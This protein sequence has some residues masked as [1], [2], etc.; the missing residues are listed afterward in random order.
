MN[1]SIALALII[2][3]GDF[4]I[5]LSR[6]YKFNSGLSKGKL[7]YTKP[8]SNDSANYELPLAPIISLS[9]LFTLYTRFFE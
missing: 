1:F 4:R 2:Y 3:S 8:E 7:C 9:T 5:M 6:F